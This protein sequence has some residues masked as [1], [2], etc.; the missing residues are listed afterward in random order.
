MEMGGG[1]GGA[2]RVTREGT[3]AGRTRGTPERDLTSHPSPNLGEKLHL[4][5]ELTRNFG[6]LSAQKLPLCDSQ[7]PKSCISHI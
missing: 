2:E 4:G 3:G 7:W 5:I 6:D 1:G